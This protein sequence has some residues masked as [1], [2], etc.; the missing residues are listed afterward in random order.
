MNRQIVYLVIAVLVVA[1]GVLGYLYYQ[2]QQKPG[3]DIDVGKNAVSI[4]TK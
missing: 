1:G 4:E 2:E 3:I